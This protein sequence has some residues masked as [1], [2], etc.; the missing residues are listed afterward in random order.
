MT[1]VT[2]THLLT[3]R[4]L[5]CP[6]RTDPVSVLDLRMRVPPKRPFDVRKS[7]LIEPHP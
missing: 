6:P 2:K 4:I 3:G 5:T 1:G 7:G